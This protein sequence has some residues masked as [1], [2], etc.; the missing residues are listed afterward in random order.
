MLAALLCADGAFR[1]ILASEV[2]RISNSV[3]KTI[4]EGTQTMSRRTDSM[5]KAAMRVTALK[6]EDAPLPQ[7]RDEVLH[8]LYR[9]IECVQKRNLY[10]PFERGFDFIDVLAYLLKAAEQ[11]AGGFYPLQDWVNKNL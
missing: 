8:K 10:A 4:R 9:I 3:Q 7:M 6:S 11:V 5:W 1:E 2:R